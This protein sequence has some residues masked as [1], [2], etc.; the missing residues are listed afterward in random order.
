MRSR[1]F[2]SSVCALVWITACG[3]EPAA[4][5]PVEHAAAPPSAPPPEV[6]PAAPTGAP[7][8]LVELAAGASHVCGLRRD[9]RVTC[10]GDAHLGALGPPATRDATPTIVPFVSDAIAVLAGEDRSC[11]VE[12]GGRLVCWGGSHELAG[13]MHE[14][15][16]GADESASVALGFET[17]A[18]TRRGAPIVADRYAS[19][20]P[21]IEGAVEITGSS[22]WMCARDEVGAV[23]CRSEGSELVTLIESGA[24]A[25]EMG[26]ERV[27]VID[28]ERRVRCNAGGTEPPALVAGID[29]AHELAVGERFGCVR[30]GDAR[31]SCWGE[32]LVGQL[33]RGFA[34]QTEDAGP[35]PG[36]DDAE[37][38]VGGRDFAC[39]RR[40]GGPIVC[41]GHI[42]VGPHRHG[43]VR[44]LWR[45][46]RPRSW[47]RDETAALH[48]AAPRR[49]EGI[50][51]ASAVVATRH[52]TCALRRD[53]HVACW[54]GAWWGNNGD[55]TRINRA[56]PV[57]VSDLDDAVEL[58]ATSNAVCAR[59]RAG[60]VACW[61]RAIGAS[62]DEMHTTPVEVEGIED[63]QA[64]LA[65]LASVC[66]RRADRTTWC[67]GRSGLLGARGTTTP[68][69]MPSLDGARSL[70]EGAN[71]SFVLDDGG[72]VT[73]YAP[74][75]STGEPA[76]ADLQGARSLAAGHDHACLVSAD[77]SVVC[78]GQN[79]R[80]QLGYEGR[81]TPGS[82]TPI[83]NL[84][85]ATAVVNGDGF[86]CALHRGGVACWGDNGYGQLGR[87]IRR[88]HRTT[89]VDVASPLTTHVVSLAAGTNHVCAVR[90]DGSVW[91]WGDGTHGQLGDGRASYHV[92]P[93]EVVLPEP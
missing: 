56:R 32:N 31:V 88:D 76:F 71:L 45:D 85:Q 47:I 84:D 23:R 1:T 33:G 90:R 9:G 61:G 58:A 42:P 69:A 10:W 13:A 72:A 55:G 86:G 39:V 93:T 20:P 34:S 87:E 16:S 26:A 65:G 6:A 24:R 91:C 29:D 5:A 52:S 22:S 50:D 57:A 28:A 80:G 18:L 83:P 12:R 67:W 60:R 2:S 43:D 73:R 78:W 68:I 49:V 48:A 59:R 77:A 79:D 92:E 25:V 11:A 35:V 63:A 82:R 44:G 21:R 75:A 51:D 3:G 17:L 30:H 4:P 70:A 8:D 46:D 27:C 36:I 62:H 19:D 54:G 66:A 15:A 74:G 81:W 14:L 41:W 40:R 89:A 38:L 53:G 64:L 7:S 37:E